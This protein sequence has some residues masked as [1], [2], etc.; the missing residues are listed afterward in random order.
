VLAGT[1]PYTEEERARI[2]EG[3][4]IPPP[5]SEGWRRLAPELRGVVERALRR[6]PGHRHADAAAFASAL[7]SA[8]DGYGDATEYLPDRAPRGAPGGAKSDPPTALTTRH[9]PR[10]MIPLVLALAL[11]FGG[12]LLVWSLSRPGNTAPVETEP[13]AARESLEGEFRALSVEGYRNLAS[14][15]SADEGA[16]AAE[17]VQAV[18]G[19]LHQTLVHGDLDAHLSLYADEVDF[20]GDRTGREGIASARRQILRRYPDRETVLTQVAIQF[21][22]PGEARALVDREWRFEGEDVWTGVAREEFVLNRV[23]GEWLIV[24]EMEMEMESV[25]ERGG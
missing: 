18:V 24:A 12:L 19:N 2:R 3:E 5:A 4:E 17:A 14:A 11:A 1:K 23:N 15:A 25:E 16:E 13:V 22:A 10:R 8:L 6:D 21:F 20:H 7:S 9:G